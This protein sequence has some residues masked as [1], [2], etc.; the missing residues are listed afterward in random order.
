[1]L[2][3]TM[4]WTQLIWV[5]KTLMHRIIA[6]ILI[7]EPRVILKSD[8]M[9]LIDPISLKMIRTIPIFALVSI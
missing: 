1:M 7:N 3:L 6:S 4:Q 8:L 5:V 9:T 2:F